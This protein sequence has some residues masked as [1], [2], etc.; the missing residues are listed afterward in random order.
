MGN[1]MTSNTSND[2]MSDTSHDIYHLYDDIPND[3]ID[4]I[5]NNIQYMQH[6][7]YSLIHIIHIKN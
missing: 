5:P 3:I 4:D 2:I 6:K 7:K 1:L